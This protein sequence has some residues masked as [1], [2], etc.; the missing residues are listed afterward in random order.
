MAATT[1]L[2]R[3]ILRLSGEEVRGFLQGLVTH[4]LALLAPER[5]LWAGLLTPQG[6][7]LFDFILWA[8]GDDVLIDCERE[9]AGEV[10]GGLPLA[11]DQDVVAVGPEDE[12]EQG[13]AL[14]SQQPGPHRQRRLEVAGD[15][16]LEEIANALAG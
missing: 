11:I 15:Q 13:L 8:D 6:K 16:P 7:A 14:R 5:P 1:L 10:A 4:D 9:A 3:A 12:I 2:D